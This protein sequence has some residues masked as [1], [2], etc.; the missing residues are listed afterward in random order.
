MRRLCDVPSCMGAAL[1][2]PLGWLC[3]K[4]HDAA[5]EALKSGTLFPP[6]AFGGSPDDA[7][8]RERDDDVRAECYA[9]W[10]GRLARL[11]AHEEHE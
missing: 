7:W 5:E 6:G 11:D 8:E 9:Q 4:H 3:A 1:D 10:L 2:H